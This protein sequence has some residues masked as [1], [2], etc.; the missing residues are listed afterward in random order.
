MSPP[1]VLFVVKLAPVTVGGTYANA[2]ELGADACERTVATR[3][4]SPPTPG[5]DTHDMSVC[6]CTTH[7]TAATSGK[8]AGPTAIH[9]PS[10]YAPALPPKLVPVTLKAV[11]PALAR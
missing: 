9:T 11:P 7:G 10:R 6:D 3:R 8:P 5:G 1:A 2:K 4:R